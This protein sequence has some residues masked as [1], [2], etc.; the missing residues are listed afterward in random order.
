MNRRCSNYL[1][2]M[3]TIFIRALVEQRKSLHCI[4][5]KSILHG[6]IKGQ[7]SKPG[8]ATEVLTHNGISTRSV[9]IHF[10]H[11]VIG[12]KLLVREA[13]SWRVYNAKGDIEITYA[14]DGEKA[15]FRKKDFDGIWT[16]PKVS[17]SFMSPVSMPAWATRFILDIN[18]IEVKLLSEICDAEADSMGVE[19]YYSETDGKWHYK[20]YFNLDS[21]LAQTITPQPITASQS[22]MSHYLSTKNARNKPY[23]SCP[24]MWLI[25]FETIRLSPGTFN[26][27]HHS[28]IIPQIKPMDV[29]PVKVSR[30]PR[31]KKA[32]ETV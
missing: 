20:D 25:G 15:V 4:E 13:W 30:T 1:I 5:V 7:G 17:R 32:L 27:Y 10:P 3:P 26:T 9:N 18:S 6:E 31:T 11:G 16:P 29:A 12:D 19:S 23:N 2:T 14:A 22:L 8:I 28:S 21:K 24:H